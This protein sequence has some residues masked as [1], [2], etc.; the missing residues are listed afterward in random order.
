MNRIG[1]WSGIVSCD[2]GLVDNIADAQER[3][4][5]AAAQHRP[6]KSY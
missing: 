1:K 2:R 5:E 4:S 3:M 6:T